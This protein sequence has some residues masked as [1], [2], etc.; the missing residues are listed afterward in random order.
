MGM[1]TVRVVNKKKPFENL[2]F[3]RKFIIEHDELSNIIEN[4]VFSN[5]FGFREIFERRQVNNI[6]FDDTKNTFYN[7]NVSGDGWRKKYR[8]RWYGDDFFQV[9]SPTLEIKR[10][11]GE[12]GDKISHKMS[13]FELSLQRESVDTIYEKVMDYFRSRDIIVFDNMSNLFPKL[14][15]TYERRYFISDCDKFRITLDYNMAYYNPHYGHYFRELPAN[16]EEIIF[17]LK[18]STMH[19][20]EC[21]I[22]TQSLDERLSKNSK[23]VRGV[24]LVYS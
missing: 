9:Q 7:E 1:N 19:D 13:G 15:N 11:Y 12:V 16:P 14:Y 22:L 17:E 20:N 10:K 2:R 5:S 18:Y 23:Y 24:D 6:Y 8:I 21:R 4:I 3:E